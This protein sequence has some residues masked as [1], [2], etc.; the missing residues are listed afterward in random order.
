MFVIGVY[1]NSHRQAHH[2]TWREVLPRVIAVG[3][4]YAVLV[5]GLVLLLWVYFAIR[6]HWQTVG[7]ILVVVGV[8]VAGL[9][10]AL[11]VLYLAVRVVRAAW[12]GR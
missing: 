11:L 8:G 10:I 1:V 2:L 4:T 12:R 7:P 9:S 5:G 3:V 6:E